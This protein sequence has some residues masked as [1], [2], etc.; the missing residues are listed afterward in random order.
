MIAPMT[1]SHAY[2]TRV[3][4][5]FLDNSAWIVLDQIRTVD[6]NWLIK[7]LGT[8]DR[9]AVKKVK[10]VIREMLVD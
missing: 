5:D 9:K 2:P 1:K 4:L 3:T 10:A 6:R 8:I 7:K